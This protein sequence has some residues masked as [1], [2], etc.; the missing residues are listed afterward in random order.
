M[1]EAVGWAVA[2]GGDRGLAELA[3]KRGW[4]QLSL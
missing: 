2:V 1:L 3:G 4:S